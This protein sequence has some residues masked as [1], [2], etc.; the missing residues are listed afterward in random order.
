MV[1][2]M[3]W[4][5]HHGL[6]GVGVDWLGLGCQEHPYIFRM[7][8]ILPNLWVRWELNSVS[9]GNKDD[10]ETSNRPCKSVNQNTY[11]IKYLLFLEIWT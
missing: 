10:G 4:I 9:G 11:A 8:E 5:L 3:V 6:D 2:G 7:T 1:G